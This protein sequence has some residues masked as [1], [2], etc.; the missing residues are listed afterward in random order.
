M[1]FFEWTD[2]Y[3]VGVQ[4][5]DR[6]HMQ[7]VDILNR[8]YESVCADDATKT[9][10]VI[11]VELLGYTRTHFANEEQLLRVHG[12]PALPEHMEEH[13]E[14]TFQAA[15]FF[16]EFRKG[17]AGVP[18]RMVSFLRDWLAK[19]IMRSDKA[20]GAYLNGKGVR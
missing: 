20:Y 16:S 13:Q 9:L 4:Q 5:I 14:L 8:L 7:L 19:H 12:Y 6:E 11:L 15:Q 10:D 3:S 2:Q 18:M 1:A 17:N